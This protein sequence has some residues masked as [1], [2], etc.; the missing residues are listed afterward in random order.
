MNRLP[1]RAIPCAL[2][3]A[4]VCGCGGPSAVN[5]KLR[6]ENQTL[7]DQIT[8]LDRQQQGDVA[9]IKAYQEHTVTTPTL[10][11]DRLE[12]LFTTHGLQFG[13][14]TGAHVP[15]PTSSASDGL[16]IYIVP[17]DGQGD[18]LKAAGSFKIEAWD[19]AE[20]TRPL[21]GSW[22]FDTAQSRTMFYDHLLL[23]TYVLI[24]PWQNRPTH[25]DLTIRATFDDELTG[26]AFTIQ[27]QVTVQ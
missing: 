27:R 12:K 20:A 3:A 6:K 2:L 11:D 5:I 15:D 9:Q 1:R 17:I 23:Y 13:M 18:R 7:R 10:S 22:T 8:E 25:S 14:L 19:L 26:R 21:L 24:C 4:L 16:Q